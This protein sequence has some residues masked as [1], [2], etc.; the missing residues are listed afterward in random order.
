[1]QFSTISF[2]IAAVMASV[3]TAAP[4]AEPKNV[5]RPENIGMGY[6]GRKVSGPRTYEPF[7]GKFGK[8]LGPEDALRE[9]EV[10]QNNMQTDCI[11]A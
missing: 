2:A 10:D 3:V 4:V 6:C 5:F 8:I 7:P 9:T 11:T 1:M